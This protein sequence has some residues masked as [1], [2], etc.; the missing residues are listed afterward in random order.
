MSKQLIGTIV[1]ILGFVIMTMRV[2]YLRGYEF[3]YV[4]SLLGLGMTFIGCLL[5][6]TYVKKKDNEET[7]G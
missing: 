4:V 2:V 1:M 5:V 3:G 6:P 7:K